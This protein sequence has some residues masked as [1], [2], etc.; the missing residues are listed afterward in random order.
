MPVFTVDFEVFC[1]ACGKGLQGAIETTSRR[2]T[3]FL[4]VEPCETCLEREYERGQA[5]K[6]PE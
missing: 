3:P 2:P 1:G 4:K 6:G 5:E